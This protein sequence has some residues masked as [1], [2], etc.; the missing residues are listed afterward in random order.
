MENAS[1][2]LIIAGGVLISLLVISLLV[3]TFN[4]I[5]NYQ[6]SLQ[7]QEATEQAVDFN[8]NFEGYNRKTLYG[9]DI[10]SIANLVV[11][12][13]TQEADEKDYQNIEVYVTISKSVG[14]SLPTG[15]SYSALEP[16]GSAVTAQDIDNDLSKL[17]KDVTEFG[18]KTSRINGKNYKYKELYSLS[19][20]QFE[21][22]TGEMKGS[23]GTIAKQVQYYENLKNYETEFKRKI[24]GCINVEYDPNNGR[25]T[26]MEFKDM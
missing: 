21:E 2:A 1:K 7:S 3:L 5:S 16:S 9:S 19:N 23:G 24:F 11:D 15:Y 26:K 13:N 4:G 25:I 12:Y 18:N 10:I 20:T 8:K 17:K 14:L 22:I 6:K